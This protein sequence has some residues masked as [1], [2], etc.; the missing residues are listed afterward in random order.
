MV[1][2][3]RLG[4]W[5]VLSGLCLGLA[6]C[7]FQ[8][9][10][11]AKFPFETINV[12]GA[13]PMLNELQRNIATGSNAKIV[14]KA[15]EAQAVFALLGEAREKVILSLNTQGRVREFQLR[16][17]VNF[18]V[19]DGKGGEFIAPSTIILRRDIS[20]NDQ[21]LAKEAEEGLLYREMQSDMV[22]QLIRR[23]QA[24][25]LRGPDDD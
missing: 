12:A 18:R 3:R 7:G 19:H 25:K 10:G 8:L 23:M 5:L 13:S 22:Q 9:R 2:A 14:A 20:F 21:V 17:R 15:D 16:Y 24:S 4:L 11:Q 1:I 6:G